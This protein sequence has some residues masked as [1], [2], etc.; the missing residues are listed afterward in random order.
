[1]SLVQLSLLV[2]NRRGQLKR[3]CQALG[4]AGLDIVTL[5]L[6]DTA[7]FGILRLV[8]RD[9]EAARRVLEAEGFVVNATEVLVVDVPDRPGG[10]GEVL[11]RF[12]QA[13]IGIEY[14]YELGTP[15]RGRQA[16]MVVRVEGA[17]AAVERLAPAG[18]RVLG[19]D[20]VLAR[21]G[22]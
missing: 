4:R 19:R 1:V 16:T 20:E 13:G 12:D 9:P 3:P 18:V 2:E 15:D 17:E 10:L 22:A 6:A 14:M 11:E 5:S 7:Q 8:V 21:I